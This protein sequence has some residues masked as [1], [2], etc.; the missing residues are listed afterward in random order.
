MAQ[1]ISDIMRSEVDLDNIHYDCN[2]TVAQ[3]IQE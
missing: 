2:A 3:L 1:E